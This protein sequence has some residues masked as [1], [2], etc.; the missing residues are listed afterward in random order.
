MIESNNHPA[1]QQPPAT[2]CG[3]GLCSEYKHQVLMSSK[4]SLFQS[5][6]PLGC[7]ACKY[8]EDVLS[9]CPTHTQLDLSRRFQLES[10][11]SLFPV[12]VDN[13]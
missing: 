2:Q 11:T 8:S 4:I 5:L 6:N 1:L 13:V 10:S 3:D 12:P 7:E 9:H